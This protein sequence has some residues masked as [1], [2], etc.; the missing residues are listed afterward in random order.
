MGLRYNW[1]VVSR[2]R[3]LKI[4]ITPSGKAPFWEWLERVKDHRGRALILTRLDRIEL[5]NLGD[6]RSIAE[7]VSELRIDFGPGY[8]AY[9]AEES[10][11]VIVLLC[12]GSKRT[13]TT[14]IEK[15]KGYWRNYRSRSDA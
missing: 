13:Q 3:R 12:G 4:Y 7:G 10:G 9:F 6:Y 14:D 11:D 1:A 2:P 8:R 5:G 15:A